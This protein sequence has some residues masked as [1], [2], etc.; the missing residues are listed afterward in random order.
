MYTWWRRKKK[1]QI[2]TIQR[3]KCHVSGDIPRVPFWLSACHI[4]FRQDIHVMITQT[5]ANHGG[6]DAPEARV[7]RKWTGRM[8][9]E[10]S[11]MDAT[12]DWTMKNMEIEWGDNPEWFGWWV[13]SCLSLSSRW[14]W[15]WL[16]RT[17]IFVRWGWNHQA[18]MLR[19]AQ[20]PNWPMVLAA[21]R[22]K[23]WMF[24]FGGGNG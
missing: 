19:K 23:L 12:A 21:A 24:F 10:A 11:K 2:V 7:E 5:L 3:P 15:W 16:S 17:N 9:V 18:A 4:S 14:L 13:D 1:Y 20:T 22:V 8:G 6:D